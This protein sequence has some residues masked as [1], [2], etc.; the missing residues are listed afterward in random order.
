[1]MNSLA[2]HSDLQGFYHSDTT[3]LSLTSKSDKPDT[4]TGHNGQQVSIIININRIIQHLSCAKRAVFLGLFVVSQHSTFTQVSIFIRINTGSVEK[5]KQVLKFTLPPLL[6]R[7]HNT[8]SQSSS[9]T[10]QTQR[11]HPF[12]SEWAVKL[13]TEVSR[14]QC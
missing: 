5:E 13:R 6:W 12:V 7:S 8:V 11:L 4:S 3:W 2:P 10:T 14:I 1:M 9:P